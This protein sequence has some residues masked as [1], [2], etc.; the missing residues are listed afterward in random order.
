MLQSTLAAG[1]T[2]LAQVEARLE[3]IERE[4]AMCPFTGG[5]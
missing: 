1:I 3:I 4:G 2:R 5:V